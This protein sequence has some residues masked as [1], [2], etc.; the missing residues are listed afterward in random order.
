MGVA[1]ILLFSA[2]SIGRVDA[3]LTAS[4]ELSSVHNYGDSMDADAVPLGDD[5][6]TEET[7]SPP[8]PPPPP[9]AGSPEFWD[10]LASAFGPKQVI[11]DD[12]TAGSTA[13]VIVSATSSVVPHNPAKQV[14]AR[15]LATEKYMRETVQAEETYRVVRTECKNHYE[16][17]T[18][19]AVLGESRLASSSV[20]DWLGQLCLE[21]DLY[22]S[23][24]AAPCDSHCHFWSCTFP[25][26]FMVAG[27][28]KH[29]R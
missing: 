16:D 26:L 14:K 2:H 3:S 1:T 7:L 17:C 29:A 13:S 25:L 27:N 4:L 23:I 22:V 24:I 5:E 18:Y 11:P 20:Y 15:L 12:S 28:T 9:A 6:A 19:W 8:P 10:Q 21:M